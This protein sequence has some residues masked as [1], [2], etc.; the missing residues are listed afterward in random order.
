MSVRCLCF[1][2]TVARAAL[3]DNNSTTYFRAYFSGGGIFRGG[4]TGARP[5]HNKLNKHRT[6]HMARIMRPG[7]RWRWNSKPTYDSAYLL[8]YC[9]CHCLSSCC[10]LTDSKNTL[11]DCVTR[12]VFL[13]LLRAEVQ[14]TS[15]PRCWDRVMV[16]CA[17]PGKAGE[18]V[19]VCAAMYAR[20]A[21]QGGVK[22]EVNSLSGIH[23]ASPLDVAYCLA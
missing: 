10:L 18:L 9:R 1:N 14:P 3:W 12:D 13:S 19:G 7:C 8:S 21:G 5:S 17:S 20:C 15:A 23:R 16:Q 22:Q 2:F 4:W 11:C 6:T